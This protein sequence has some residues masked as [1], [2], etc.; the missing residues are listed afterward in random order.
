MQ[1]AES[2]KNRVI[3][4]TGATGGLG[5]VLAMAFAGA[6]ATVVLHA[7][8]VRKLEALFDRIVAAGGPEPAILPLDFE[9]PSEASFAEAASELGRQLGRLDGLVHCAATL[10]RLAPIEHHSA[11]DWNAVLSVDLASPALL[12]R[13]ML[14]LLRASDRASVVFTLDSRGH[15]PGAY[16]GSYAAAKAGLE[17]LV[18]VLGDEWESSPALSA[19]GIIPGPIATPMRLRTHPGDDP[20]SL[21]EPAQLIPLYL[22]CLGPQARAW[23]G[24]AIDAREW[25]VNSSL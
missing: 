10:K 8:V 19:I 17:A 3:L 9:R 2:L 6:G 16:W 5:E 25:L 23:S 22:R 13:S 24:Q 21:L 11:A 4:L 1:P 7:R 20:A 12:T 18:R 14:P 15:V